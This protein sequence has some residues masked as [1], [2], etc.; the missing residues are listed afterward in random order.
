MKKI[1]HNSTRFDDGLWCRKFPNS[2]RN[3]VS[4]HSGVFIRLSNRLFTQ[5]FANLMQICI[6]N[7]DSSFSSILWS[8]SRWRLPMHDY[9]K[10]RFD[11]KMM[12]IL[13]RLGFHCWVKKEEVFKT[14]F[15]VEEG[16]S[17]KIFCRSRN[18]LRHLNSGVCRGIQMTFFRVLTQIFGI[19]KKS[20][21]NRARSRFQVL[22]SQ[23]PV[24]VII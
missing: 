1:A 24:P 21:V 8:E 18:S 12:V 23:V 9:I 20:T 11:I 6:S 17:R 13:D 7:E 22:D 3:Q 4:F 15:R 10:T 2:F 19:N 14:L 5:I 16:E